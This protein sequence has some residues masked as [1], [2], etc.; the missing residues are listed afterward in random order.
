MGAYTYC[1][2][3]DSGLGAPSPQEIV[4]G[5]RE[6]RGCGCSI[7]VRDTV[8]ELIVRLGEVVLEE[9]PGNYVEI[10]LENGDLAEAIKAAATFADLKA[11][12]ARV[13]GA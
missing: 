1:A 6:C 10:S 5:T 2:C 8:D 13:I 11:I 7:E 12:L 9:E 3:C 4:D